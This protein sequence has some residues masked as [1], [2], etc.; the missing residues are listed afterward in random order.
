M[1]RVVGTQLIQTSRSKLACNSGK[2]AF[3]MRTLCFYRRSLFRSIAA[4]IQ[5]FGRVINVRVFDSRKSLVGGF[6][7]SGLFFVA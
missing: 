5:S 7:S 4:T 3:S 6:V 2:Q 1:D